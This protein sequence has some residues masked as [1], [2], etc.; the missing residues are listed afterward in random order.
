MIFGW[1]RAV[2]KAARADLSPTRPAIDSIIL[3][4][5]YRAMHANGDGTNSHPAQTTL[6]TLTG[7][8]RVTIRKVDNWLV[9]NGLMVHIRNLK[10]GLKDYALTIP[11]GGVHDHLDEDDEPTQMVAGTT[12]SE[13]DGGPD[14]GGDGGP[15]GGGDHHNLRTSVTS[16]P[17]TSARES[18]VT[19]TGA[20]ADVVALAPRER[21]ELVTR[22]AAEADHKLR[23]LVRIKKHEIL[24][25]LAELETRFTPEA[26]T[27]VTHDI[28]QARTRYKYTSD[29]ETDMLDRLDAM[30]YSGP[31]PLLPQP[32]T[33]AFCGECDGRGLIHHD[34][35][36]AGYSTPCPVGQTQAVT[37]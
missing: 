12:N 15:D 27:A 1:F 8:D 36:G 19:E 18:R 13:S 34:D 37:A 22:E 23:P 30:S 10:A 28:V 24:A 2:D 16:V 7:R 33:H 26:I 32:M 11:D 5:H 6:A 35:G 3:V 4:A 14:G 17:K 31:D 9:A 21:S 29:L 25:L 20:V